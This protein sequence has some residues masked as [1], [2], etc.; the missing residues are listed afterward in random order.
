MD[1]PPVSCLRLRRELG[2]RA[3][4]WA[5]AGSSEGP[6]CQGSTRWAPKGQ[7]SQRSVSGSGAG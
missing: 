4:K 7:A 6:P 3:R 2:T 5:K 1:R